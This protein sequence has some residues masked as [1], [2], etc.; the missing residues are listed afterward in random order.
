VIELFQRWPALSSLPHV[1]LAELPTP[2]HALP[3]LSDK[4]D[5]RVWIKRDDLTARPYGGN[6]VRKLE[7]LLGRARERGADA[8]ITAGG[9]GSH[10]VFATA[11]YGREHGF[12]VHAIVTP[13]PYHLH[14]E[15]QLRAD[16]AVG[17]H[18]VGAQRVSDVVRE[19]LI[20]AAKLRRKGKHPYLIPMGGS[21]VWGVL[22]FV[23]AGIEL[24][25]QIDEGLCPDPDAVYVSCGTCATAAGLALGLAAAGV[26]TRVV[27]V[28]TTERWLANPFRLKRLVYKAEGL[29]RAKERRFPEVAARAFASIELDH[30]EFGKG[31]GKPTPSSEAAAHLADRE[32][33]TLDPTYTS[34]ALAALVRDAEAERHGKKLL[35]WNTLSSASLEPFLRDAPDVPEEFVRLMTLDH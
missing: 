17:A 9:V 35:F 30:V 31:Y 23:N 14:V 26:D 32:G 11:L 3:R 5:S 18:L 21:N 22:G 10:H 6:K 1:P 2:V 28:R 29:L 20:S 24:A 27:A 15:D 7:F 16:L 33:I 12:E 13:Q 19:A 34:K 4:L 8:L 25:H